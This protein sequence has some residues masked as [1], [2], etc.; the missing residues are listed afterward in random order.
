M[1]PLKNRADGEP[2]QF[3]Y[4]VEHAPCLSST[5][6]GFFS[7]CLPF[8]RMKKFEHRH[9]PLTPALGGL[10]L[11]L[12][13]FGGVNLWLLVR[14]YQ[15]SVR[16]SAAFSALDRGRLL[17]EYL[18]GQPLVAGQSDDSDEWRRFDRLVHAIHTVEK[19]VLYVTVREGDVLLYRAQ[20]DAAAGD[21]P[22]TKPG[23]V[24]VGRRK[25]SS[26]SGE[27]P[28]ITFAMDA[29]S[30]RSVEL[31]LQKDFIERR[32]SETGDAVEG[33]FRMALAVFAVVMLACFVLVALLARR[34]LRWQAAL[35][36]EE[37]MA[38]AGAIAGGVLHD[39]R[40][41]LS[42]IHLDVQLLEK[43][44]E[45]GVECRVERA[46]ELARRIK[47][48]VSRVEGLLQEFAVLARQPPAA[49]DVFDLSVCVWQCAEMAGPRFAAAGLKLDVAPCPS[50]LPVDGHEA[51]IKR[52]LLNV[53]NNA[54]HFAPA[55]TEVTI[56]ARSDGGTAVVEISDRG[57]GVEQK[58]R[59]RIFDLFF[60]RRP[61][62]M[63][64]GLALA[65]TAIE[66]CGGSIALK[67][68]EGGGACIIV[69]LPL[70]PGMQAH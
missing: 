63:G 58:D 66:R 14:A 42:S 6:N 12:T 54:E 10:V 27:T 22:G 35:R 8:L 56:R 15:R 69:R 7:E 37:H 44:A 19:G 30:G 55:G 28:A 5:N 67:D 65:K 26:G 62:G 3:P 52:A 51:E 1:V 16:D 49:T 2:A 21:E 17:A 4:S 23:S 33:L 53:I 18:A 60:S 11:L 36:R 24:I 20:P 47:K 48:T 59:E 9:V 50:P 25:V 34:E 13:V 46:A 29:A 61:G 68:S 32:R 43:E 64:I 38:F 40:N 31:A 41:P 70:S 45:K 39:F 57:P